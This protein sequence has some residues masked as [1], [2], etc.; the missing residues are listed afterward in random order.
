VTLDPTSSVSA[1]VNPPYVVDLRRSDVRGRPSVIGGSPAKNPRGDSYD[2]SRASQIVGVLCVPFLPFVM[3]GPCTE[4]PLP[5]LYSVTS[6]DE[7]RTWLN[8]G[9]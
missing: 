3:P 1:K 4:M 5:G 7:L 9:V 6:I 8:A 2:F